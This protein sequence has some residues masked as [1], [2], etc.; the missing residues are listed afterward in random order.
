MKNVLCRDGLLADAG[1]GKSHILGNV[2]VQ[3]VA[4]HQHVEMFVHGVDRVRARGVG[5]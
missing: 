1:V 4:D 5:R 3:M 2:A